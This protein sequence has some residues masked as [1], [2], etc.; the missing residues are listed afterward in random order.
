MLR[1]M[2]RSLLVIAIASVSWVLSTVDVHTC[3]C[4][5]SPERQSAERL[6]RELARDLDAALAVF[7]GEPIAMNSLAIRF[8]VDSLQLLPRPSDAPRDARHEAGITTHVDTGRVC[9]VGRRGR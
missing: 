2:R 7:V 6:T 5:G 4:A 9:R 1:D 3:V 8:R